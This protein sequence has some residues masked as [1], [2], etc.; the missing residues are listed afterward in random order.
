MIGYK[1]FNKDLTC[2]DFQ[3][4]IGITYEFY[5]K[6]ILC[7]Q[8]FHF[9]KTIGGCYR[10]YS[11]TTDTR[12]CKVEA[13]GD[14]VESL[15]NDKCC[16][17]KIKIIEEITELDRKRVN[18]DPSNT[19]YFNTGKNNSG[20]YNTGDNNT[21]NYNVGNDNSGKC[22]TGWNNGGDSNTGDFNTGWYNSGDNNSGDRN[23]GVHNSGHFNSGSWNRGM[24]NT[25]CYNT[26]NF[27]TGSFNK[28]SYNSGFYNVGDGNT[29]C[30]NTTEEKIRF[31]NKPS[32]YTYSD[33]TTS[34]EATIMSKVMSPVFEMVE[35]SIEKLDEGKAA[36]LQWDSLT[37][38]EQ[39]I[40]KSLPNF[41]AEIFYQ[42]TGIKV[43]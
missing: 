17:N 42:C 39:E 12:I 18:A 21:G 19:G 5:G 22:N 37:V 13:L 38:K 15:D 25:G 33:W 26:G 14:I 4:E 6:P 29:G 20:H 7:E 1:A 28:G 8:G 27:N 41:D 40:I 11:M 2:R 43:D 23:T 24:L 32:N 3:Y 16:T 36:Q 34:E 30:F 9:C 10:Y 31:F 35:G